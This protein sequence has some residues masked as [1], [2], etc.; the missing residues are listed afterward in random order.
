MGLLKNLRSVWINSYK[1]IF[2]HLYG[3]MPLSGS[4]ESDN[5]NGAIEKFQ[6]RLDKVTKKFFLHLYGFML[7]SGSIES[8]NRNGAIEKFE[9]RSDKVTTKK[10]CACMASCSQVVV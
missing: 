5:R 8:D 1:E 10:I 4:I 9:K 2:L 6:N 7:L 3:F